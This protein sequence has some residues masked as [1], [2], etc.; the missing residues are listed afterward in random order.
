MRSMRLTTWHS[1][2]AAYAIWIR[3]AIP[4]DR[5][6]LGQSVAGFK[7][8]TPWLLNWLGTAQATTSRRRS[9]TPKVRCAT[10]SR[11]RTATGGIRMV[12]TLRLRR[13]LPMASM[14]ASS[15]AS[16]PWRPHRTDHGVERQRGLRA[17]LEPALADVT[18]RRLCSSELQR[19]SQCHA[20]RPCNGVWQ[21]GAGT[22]A[23]ADAVAA[24]TTGRPG[25]SVRAPSGTSP[26]TSTWVSTCVPEA[27]ER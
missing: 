4:S 2:L 12:A 21:R 22:V 25:G 11:P 20:L 18:L 10:S 15:A 24:T 8:N 14:A 16:G 5:A 17:L 9:T 26:R 6:G 3:A 27:A 23:P 19:P 13:P 7:L 1:A